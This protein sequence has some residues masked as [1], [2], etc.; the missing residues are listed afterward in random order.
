MEI[1]GLEISI[2]LVTSMIR[3]ARNVIILEIMINSGSAVKN[4]FHSS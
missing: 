3:Y 4:E 2:R 1:K